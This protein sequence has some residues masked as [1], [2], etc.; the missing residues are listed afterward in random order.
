MNI[1]I[2]GG[3]MLL[4][5]H[6]GLELPRPWVVTGLLFNTSILILLWPLASDMFSRQRDWSWE[7]VRVFNGR[8]PVW[9][10]VVAVALL[11]FGLTSHLGVRTAGNFSMQ[12]SAYRGGRLQ[13][14]F[15]DAARFARNS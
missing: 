11:V 12:E 10:Y 1:V 8:T 15:V 6:A 13:P 4:V 14:S 2:G 3:L 5:N 9:L 7:G